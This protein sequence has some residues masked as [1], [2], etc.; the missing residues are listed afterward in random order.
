MEKTVL[1]GAGKEVG[2]EVN[3]EKINYVFM[4]YHQ[5]ARENH[6]LMVPNKSF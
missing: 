6:N 3:A 5:N 4:Y 2:L 1:L